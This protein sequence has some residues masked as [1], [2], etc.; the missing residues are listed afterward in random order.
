VHLKM[1]QAAMEVGRWA[2]RVD[3]Q[4]TVTISKA[5]AQVAAFN[6]RARSIGKRIEIFRVKLDRVTPITDSGVSIANGL[7]QVAPIMPG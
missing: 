4:A 7:M 3:G 2:S 5:P 6:P 1:R